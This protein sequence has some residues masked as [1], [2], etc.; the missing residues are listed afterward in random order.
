MTDK[1][2]V[3]DLGDAV[4]VED[5]DGDI[6]IVLAGESTTGALVSASA[7][8]ASASAA[9]TS[10]TNASASATNASAS[11]TNASASAA[12]AASDRTLV[13]GI[14]ASAG[15]LKR[16][17]TK[18]L[19]DAGIAGIAANEF[20]EVQADE[21]FADRPARYQK[22]SGS[23]VRVAI[24]Y[25]SP[26]R[27]FADKLG[28]DASNGRS[29]AAAKQTLAAANAITASGDTVKI[30]GQRWFEKFAPG[31]SGQHTT[32]EPYGGGRPL[33]FDGSRLVPAVSWTAH[34][35]HANVWVA[36]V[37]H[38]DATIGAQAHYMAWQEGD[39][40]QR[41]LEPY[42]GGASI[43]AND[44]FVAAAPGRFTVRKTG[45]TNP[46][47]RA[48]S[49]TGVATYTYTVRLFDD[50]NPNAGP[51]TVY[52]A[53]HGHIA[54]FRE[55]TNVRG[56]TF[57]RTAT[58]DAVASSGGFVL[59]SFSERMG[60]F[61][62]CAF[63]DT[64][65]HGFVGTL[66]AKRCRAIG[67]PVF[68]ASYSG[69]YAYHFFRDTGAHGMSD[70][71][72]A[73]DVYAKGYT[74]AFHS[75][76]TGGGVPEHRRVDIR[77]ARVEDCNGAIF[78]G[79][80][81]EG[82]FAEDIEALNCQLLAHTSGSPLDIK[83]ATFLSADIA[84]CRG[85]FL[86]DNVTA[87]DLTLIF[88]SAGSR[89]VFRNANTTNFSVSLTR[90]NIVDGLQIS[91]HASNVSLTIADCIMGQMGNPTKLN[92][93]VATN[94]QLQM[95]ARTL[96]EIQAVFAGVANSCL[97]PW[98]RQPFTTT[99]LPD[100]I[101]WFNTT[102][103][104]TGTAGSTAIAMNFVDANTMFVGQGLR[105][106]DWDGAGNNFDTKLVSINTTG[107][108]GSITVADA[109]PGNFTSKAC[110]RAHFGRQIFPQG[111]ATTGRLSTSGA[112]ITVAD[113]RHFSVGLTIRIEGFGLRKIT[114]ISGKTLTLDRPCVWQTPDNLA[115]NWQNPDGTGS[116][117]PIPDLDI[118]FG[119]PI[120]YSSTLTPTSATVVR[121]GVTYGPS[122]MN[123]NSVFGLFAFSLAGAVQS[124]GAIRTEEG[125]IATGFP[126]AAGDTISIETAVFVSDYLPIWE[127][128]PKVSGKAIPRAGSEIAARG[129]GRRW[130]R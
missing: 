31:T 123:S 55:G 107:S 65:M 47:P 73:E 9:A 51:A 53:D 29:P 116:G 84:N 114:A 5:S 7:A 105:F 119:F 21:T 36:N 34:P 78:V 33:I 50:A 97:V 92:S 12:A 43:A 22:Q 4:L 46:D 67:R 10:A 112:A 32:V 101:A 118:S 2:V 80:S 70:G 95:D 30:K 38:E 68:G 26:A 49:E 103:F 18:A 27:I 25:Q 93:L 90:A 99:V 102:R 17:A 110:Q 40:K 106:I 37:T 125:Y 20:V 62:D 81:E 117:V 6:T 75:H 76:G 94:S 63:I 120:R 54:W 88:R 129:I 72:L 19:M 71:A 58:K 79:E 109:A 85:F 91:D 100:D 60:V 24:F 104:G 28:S 59:G 61:E 15:A 130:A 113:A 69:G 56:I 11:A 86:N 45:S 64:A 57:Q 39:A 128:D 83:R 52:V 126:V 42:W 23:L 98:V 16:Y 74:F 87:E 115:V 77:R 41:R 96:E 48:G 89:A 108:G 1:I 44:A 35:T 122:S 3:Q 111:V 14:A 127:G 82:W 66:I 8:A 121:S 124:Q 13:E